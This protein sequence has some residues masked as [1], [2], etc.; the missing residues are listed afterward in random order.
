MADGTAADPI[1]FT[2][3]VPEKGQWG[4]ITIAGRAPVNFGIL[5]DPEDEASFVQSP[6]IAEVRQLPYGGST[7]GDNSGTLNYVRVEYGGAQL[8]PESEFNAFTF[9]GVG[10]GTTLTNLQAYNGKDDGFE[11]FG[12]TVNAS[13]LVATGSGDDSVDWTE[14]WTGKH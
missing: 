11:F 14:G 4:G 12:G 6:A 10:S 2:A 13:N 1:V 5:E 8:T 7:P 9:Y 3:D